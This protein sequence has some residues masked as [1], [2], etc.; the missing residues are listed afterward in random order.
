MQVTIKC[1]PTG[2]ADLDIGAEPDGKVGE[3]DDAGGV[4]REPDELRLVEV[5]RNV[6]VTTVLK[7]PKL[8][9]V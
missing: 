4:A 9:C 6:P 8:S 1:F 3:P 7:L 5:F 2:L